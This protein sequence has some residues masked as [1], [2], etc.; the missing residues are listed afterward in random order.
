MEKLKMRTPA[1]LAFIISSFISLNAFAESSPGLSID[2]TLSPAGSFKAET[3]KIK[4]QAVKK[5]SK[6]AARG[7]VV[8]LRSIDTGIALRNEHLQKRLMVDK[9]PEA[10]LVKAIGED[11]KGDAILKLKGMQLQV[12]GTYTVTEDLLT[13]KFKVHLPDLKIQD[14]RYMG[15][16]VEDDVMVTIT[17]PV[18]DH[19]S[20]KAAKK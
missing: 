10:V 14:V 17:V 4:G 19:D 11:G 7:I 13:A 3:D 9:H 6:V 18:K 2:V 5:G 12:K 8:D 16:G 15:V 20:M 1:L